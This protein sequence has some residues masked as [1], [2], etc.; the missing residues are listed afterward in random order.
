MRDSQSSDTQTLLPGPFCFCPRGISL[1]HPSPGARDTH[2]VCL[3]SGASGA[4]RIQLAEAPRNQ[5]HSVRPRGIS[6]HWKRRL[7]RDALKQRM[8]AWGPSSWGE[9]TSHTWKP[10]PS[11][12]WHPDKDTLSSLV[13]GWGGTLSPLKMWAPAP[14]TPQHHEQKL[15]QPLEVPHTKPAHSSQVPLS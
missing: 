6:N 13:G 3:S 7:R 2:V 15:P 14:E 1:P 9:P 5:S 11:S 4:E 12:Q 8:S 10:P